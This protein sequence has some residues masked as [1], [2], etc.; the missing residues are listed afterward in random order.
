MTDTAKPRIAVHARAGSFSERWVEYCD[1]RGLPFQVVDCRDS[2]IISKLRGFD[3]LLW[4]WHQNQPT[5][6]LIAR[7]VIR[8]AETMGL[9]AFPDT[10]TCWSYDDKIAQK[11]QLESVG[12]PLA[13][14]EALYEK[15][16]ALKWSRSAVYPLVFKLRCGAGSSN[17][18]LLKGPDDA[19]KVIEQAF[20]RGFPFRPPHLSEVM[21]NLKKSRRIPSGATSVGLDPIGKIR[22]FL[23]RT[24]DARRLGRLMGDE[25]GYALMQEFLTDN[26]FDTRITVIGRRA[27]GFTRNV[28][29]GDWRASG[30]GDISYEASRI[31]PRCVALAFDAADKLGCA[32]IAIDFV[33]AGDGD[34]RILEISYCYDAEAVYECPGHWGP[35]LVWNPGH[36]HPQDA[37]LEDLIAAWRIRTGAGGAKNA[38]AKAQEAAA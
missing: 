2:G 4:H 36:F 27:F 11:Y 33:R 26:Y 29:R 16:T 31:D 23:R 14:T 12:A 8:A 3:L 32:S 13:R 17:V 38:G 7:H 9:L 28:R 37:I 24:A 21:D 10:A 22:R 34:P 18:K 15:E 6:R 19:A 25:I 5:D 35:D 20:N 30:S 1:Q